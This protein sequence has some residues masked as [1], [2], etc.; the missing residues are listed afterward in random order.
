MRLAL[1]H[2]RAETIEYG[3]YP[4]YALPALAFPTVMMLLFGRQLQHGEP[5]RMVA[6]L[7]ASNSG[8]M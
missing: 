2:A 4:S 7:P 1:A 8:A 3:R 5:E 6:G